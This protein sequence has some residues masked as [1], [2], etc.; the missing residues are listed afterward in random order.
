MVETKLNPFEHFMQVH[1]MLTPQSHAIKELRES[2][3]AD[4][5]VLAL[6]PFELTDW[7]DTLYESVAPSGWNTVRFTLSAGNISN[8]WMDSVQKLNRT[9]TSTL[10]G[11]WE[12]FAVTKQGERLRTEIESTLGDYEHKELVSNDVS[13]NLFETITVASRWNQLPQMHQW[14][15]T[16]AILAI[17]LS[18]IM[19]VHMEGLMILEELDAVR[20]KAPNQ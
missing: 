19:N 3:V 20:R 4:H 11:E 17:V 5:R 10:Y 15:D 13:I 1:T 9:L 14:K 16:E 2:G 7:L 18:V 8:G 12:S 6:Y